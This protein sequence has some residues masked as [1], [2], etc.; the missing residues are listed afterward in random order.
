[1][2]PVREERMRPDFPL[3]L[4]LEWG[5]IPAF[6]GWALPLV[7]SGVPLM[8]GDP[9]ENETS[10]K[11]ASALFTDPGGALKA[12]DTVSVTDGK[13][14][15]FLRGRSDTRSTPVSGAVGGVRMRALGGP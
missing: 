5:G 4:A 3:E 15:L 11:S 13:L 12:P 6:C 10:C 9:G 2:G 8:H 1:M 14:Q 7:P